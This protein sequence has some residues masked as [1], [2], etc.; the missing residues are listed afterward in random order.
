MTGGDIVCQF[1]KI[2]VLFK[3]NVKVADSKSMIRIFFKF[4]KLDEVI[5]R[6]NLKVNWIY[7][8]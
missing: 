7:F 1:K 5:L 4:I 2:K 6:N 3:G 8:F